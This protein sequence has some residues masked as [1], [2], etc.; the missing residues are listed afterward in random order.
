MSDELSELN[1]RQDLQEALQA[2]DALRWK[3]EQVA[4]LGIYVSLS[5][6]SAPGEMFQARLLW[7]IYPGEPPSLKFRDPATCRLDLPT[8]WPV[9]RGF[10]PQSLDACVNY[11]VEGF[12]LHP[13][14]KN[15]ANLKW[16]DVGN[17]L[18]WVVRRLQDELDNHYTKRF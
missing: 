14:W 7:K 10:R 15:D 16:S 13:E 9:V 12:N 5:P 2:E 11:C 1:F 3:I 4:P 6:A 18:L 17:R 8:A